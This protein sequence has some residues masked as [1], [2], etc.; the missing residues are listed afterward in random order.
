MSHLPIVDTWRK[1]LGLEKIPFQIYLAENE[2][3]NREINYHTSGIQWNDKVNE[4]IIYIKYPIEERIIIHELGHLYH[5]KEYND[6]SIVK[7]PKPKNFN[8]ELDNIRKMICDAFTDYHLSKFERYYYLSLKEMLR[9]VKYKS[10]KGLKFTQYLPKYILAYLKLNYVL[11]PKDRS[12][13][14]Q[15]IKSWLKDSREYIRKGN[16]KFTYRTFQQ[17]DSLLNKFRKIRDK[18][19]AQVYY[20]FLDSILH[21]FKTIFETIIET[22]LLKFKTILLLFSTCFFRTDLS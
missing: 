6:M 15:Y 18:K 7:I 8:P 9:G 1:K 22:A 13:N 19:D 16:P 14:T 20:K 5:A 12:N 10:K 4:F 11:S 17:L 3:D 21:F 2:E